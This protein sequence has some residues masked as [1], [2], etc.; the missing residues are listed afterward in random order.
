MSENR[1]ARRSKVGQ[2][3]IN[4][5]HEEYG[6]EAG[7]KACLTDGARVGHAA[8]AHG[9]DDECADGDGREEIHRLIAVLESLCIRRINIGAH[10]SEHF[11]HRCPECAQKENHKN[12]EQR[13]REHLA[14]AVDELVRIERQIVRC[15][16]EKRRVDDLRK[17]DIARTNEG[18]N[19]DLKRDGAR[20]RHGEQRA[21]DEI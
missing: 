21:N 3:A 12:D 11:P 6:D 14:H 13:G 19:A 8:I 10:R 2:G 15:A 20:P 7:R 18:T 1:R 9:I 4:A 17:R 5:G 16:K